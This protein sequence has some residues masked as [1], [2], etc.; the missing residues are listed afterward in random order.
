M[1]EITEIVRFENGELSKSESLAMFQRLINSG[2][3]FELGGW[4]SEKAMELVKHG[5]CSLPGRA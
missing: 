3:A 5:Y 2:T 1:D 4:Y